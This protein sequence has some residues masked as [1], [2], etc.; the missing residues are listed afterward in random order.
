MDTEMVSHLTLPK[1]K[2]V[3][4]VRQALSAIESGCD[5]V[6]ANEIARQVKAGLSKEPGIYLNFDPQHYLATGA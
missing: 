4:V 5:E 6:L 2:P 3:N 1:V